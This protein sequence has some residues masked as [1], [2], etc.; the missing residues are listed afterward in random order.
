MDPMVIY[1]YQANVITL[2]DLDV[3]PHNFHDL[4]Y[5]QIKTSLDHI[6]LSLSEGSYLLDH[7]PGTFTVT[8]QLE[9][10]KKGRYQK[11]DV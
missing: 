5:V 9:M 8:A 2:K 11:Y 6:T 7:P 10:I 1:Q 4:G 3:Q